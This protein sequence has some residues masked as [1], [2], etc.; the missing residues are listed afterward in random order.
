MHHDSHDSR[1]LSVDVRSKTLAYAVLDG[2]LQLLDFGVSGS[3]QPGFQANRIEKLVRKFQPRIIVL[4]KVPTGSKRD[5]PAV[6]AAIKNIRI[7]ARR[8]PVSVVSIEK[9]F[10]DQT[11]RQHCKPTKRQIALLLS[12]GFPALKWYLPNERKIWM[13]E[14]RRMQYFD[15]AALGMAY[16]A[17]EGDVEPIQQFLS[18][19]AFLNR[20]PASGA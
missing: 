15:A 16:F 2:P 4:R 18:D 10:I 6:Q 17:S 11:F 1:I 3:A 5:S 20:L 12:A 19:A 13:P 14:D 8:L 7:T 9:R